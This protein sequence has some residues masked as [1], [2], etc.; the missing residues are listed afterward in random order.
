[1]NYSMI[2]YIIGWVLTLEAIFLLL[3]CL[4]AVIY[5]EKSGLAFLAV[6][7]VCAV[8]GCLLI[9]KKPEKRNY[10]AREGFVIVSLSWITM[11]G[12]QSRHAAQSPGGP[13]FSRP[14]ESA[15]WNKTGFPLL[16]KR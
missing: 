3:P 16:R 4:V 8:I 10:Y 11:P 15:P 6:A 12:Y 13:V 5:R 9:R 14:A 1:M 2:R 7:V